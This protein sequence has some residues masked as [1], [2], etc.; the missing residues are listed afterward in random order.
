MRVALQ[1]PA[2][3]AYLDT[4]I[5]HHGNK[6][7]IY[8]PCLPENNFFPD[9]SL[10]KEADVIFICSPNNPTG[11]VLSY[12]ELQEIVSFA[13][14]F[15]KIIIF[16]SAY[17][18][19][20]S[21]GHPKSIYEIEGAK[22][23]A[24]EIGSFSKIAG[25]SG[26]R[27]GWTVVP[28]ELRYAT[29]EPVRADWMRLITTFY[30]GASYISQ[31]GGLAALSD[32]GLE[33]I[34]AQVSFYLTNAKM[35]R[36]AFLDLGYEAYGGINSPYLWVRAAGKTSWQAFEELLE[37]AHIIT[38]PGVGFGPAGEGFLRISG[39]AHRS[40][41]EEAIARLNSKK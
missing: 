18:F 5:I 35:L 22:E 9:L 39:F 40:S 31:H 34:R 25:F 17:S 30:N 32:K 2:Y 12:K 24:I 3:P 38:T 27:L 37:K 7:I 33:E 19:Y 26:V 8:L 11:S 36:R 6:D 29:S 4:S 41:I 15:Q 21:N 20:V 28:S 14:A 1:D 13:K 10:A 16:D 23:V